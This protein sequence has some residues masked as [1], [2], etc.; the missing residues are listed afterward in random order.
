MPSDGFVFSWQSSPLGAEGD[1]EKQERP[2][3]VRG[4]RSAAALTGTAQY[5]GIR[6][7]DTGLEVSGQR[8][9]KAGSANPQVCP[10]SSHN[11]QNA[12]MLSSLGH[13]TDADL[14]LTISRPPTSS[15]LT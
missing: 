9:E 12:K 7:G 8:P 6:S 1:P 14:T 5:S 10:V 2:S 11:F 4:R 13:Q 3:R 15:P